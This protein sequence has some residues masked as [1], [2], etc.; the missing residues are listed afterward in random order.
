MSIK[1]RIEELQN[2]SEL[3]KM[4]LRLEYYKSKSTLISIVVSFL[5][6]ISTIIV[7]MVLEEKRAK[8]DFEL[9]TIEIIMNSKNPVEAINKQIVLQELFPNRV[10][11]NLAEKLQNLYEVNDTRVN[12]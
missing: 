5:A 2:V 11:I 1:R 3:E 6:I 9:K 8:I 7:N 4:K 12:K 10:S